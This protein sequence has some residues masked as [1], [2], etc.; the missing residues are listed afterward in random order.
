M[1]ARSV[2]AL[3][4]VGALIAPASALAQGPTAARAEQLYTEAKRLAASGSFAAACPMFEES[5]KLEPA[6]GTQF[7]LADCYERTARPATALV[8]FREVARVAQMSG[9]QERQRSAEERSAALEHVVPRVRVTSPPSPRIGEISTRIDGKLVEPEDLTRGVPLDPGEHVLRIEATGYVPWTSALTVA[10]GAALQ[11]GPIVDVAPPALQ[12]VAPVILSAP[13]SSDQAPGR[14]SV[15]RPVGFAMMGAGV[16]VLGA[17]ALFGLSAISQKND[18]NC[19]GIDCSTAAEGSGDKLRDAQAAGTISTICFVG[20]GVLAVGGLVLF[21]VAPR[22]AGGAR[23]TAAVLP[24]SGAM[25][26]ERSF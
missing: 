24:G 12:P 23:A 14:T 2:V 20:G 19:S 22:R 17:G 7:N 18:A 1:R 13:A 11:D 16:L 10:M 26:F 15:L 6:I 8:L 3:V 9:K 4:L 25:M 5:Q 21:L